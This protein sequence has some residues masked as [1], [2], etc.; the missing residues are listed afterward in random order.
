M[1]AVAWFPFPECISL[2]EEGRIP[3]CIYPKELR[4]V[5]AGVQKYAVFVK[6][7]RE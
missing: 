7:M 4:M 5:E 1:E 2:V 3:N 6:N